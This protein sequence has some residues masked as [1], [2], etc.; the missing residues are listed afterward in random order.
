MV[1]MG[2]NEVRLKAQE[3]PTYIIEVCIEFL[4]VCR[5]GDSVHARLLNFF[6]GLLGKGDGLF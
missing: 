1:V 2:F 4:C 6:G 5:R 3:F